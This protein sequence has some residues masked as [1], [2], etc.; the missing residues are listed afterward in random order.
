LL[1]RTPH[2]LWGA[3]DDRDIQE[4]ATTL[5][6]LAG[7]AAN[8]H[9]AD[10]LELK[11]MPIPD[12]FEFLDNRTQGGVTVDCFQNNRMTM[13]EIVANQ[14]RQLVCVFPEDLVIYLEENISEFKP[15]RIAY[16]QPTHLLANLASMRIVHDMKQKTSTRTSADRTVEEEWCTRPG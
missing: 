7:P 1:L 13:T 11:T 6:E 16:L 8:Q 4:E 3:P 14:L 5:S 10:V 2:D 15:T 12:V 9:L